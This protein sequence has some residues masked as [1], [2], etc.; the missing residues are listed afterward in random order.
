MSHEGTDAGMI[1]TEMIEPLRQD[2]FRRIWTASLLSNTG[3][4]IQGVGAGWAMVEMNGTPEQVALVQTAL[5]LP[6]TLFALP[7]GAIADIYDRRLVIL[8]SIIASLVGSVL[9]SIAVFG[10]QVGPASLLIFTFLVGSGMAL[11]GPSWQASVG[12][13]VTPALL[14][15]A[16]AL[17]SVSF[18]VARS[19]GPAIGGVIVA[20]AGV[21][22]AFIAAAVCYLPLIA[23]MIL[24]KRAREIPRLPPERLIEATV[25][26]LRYVLHSPRIRTP[27]W[28]TFSA[29]FAGTAIAALLPLIAR[30]IL[31]G[32]SRIFG[33]LLGA[34]GIGAVLGGLA[35]AS[36][37]AKFSTEAIM[38]LC[39]LSLAT[40]AVVVGSSHSQIV[41]SLALAVAG[42][43]WL[44]SVAICNISIQLTAPRW[45]AGRTLATFQAATAGG[46]ALGGWAWGRAATEIG[47]A[48][49]LYASAALLVLV[50]LILGRWMPMPIVNVEDKEMSAQRKELSA[51]LALTPRSGPIAVEIDYRIAPDRARQFYILVQELQRSRK[52]NGAR[53][54]SVARDI[55]DPWIWRER[56]VCATWL[57]FLR[58]R[59]RPTVKEAQIQKEV[60]ALHAGPE[61]IRAT[62]MLERPMGSV[63]WKEATPDHGLL[64]IAPSGVST[65]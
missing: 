53:S 40:M 23:V 5:T 41:T 42:A 29:A 22:A 59:D 37:R 36:L 3:R 44:I 20:W 13:Q 62:I 57:D 49:A 63:R 1:S 27:L 65:P 51:A 10:G 48:G 9:L 17:N 56:Y 31:H 19:F 18:N 43:C 11:F 64:P 30:D 50:A 39:S 2:L 35:L 6:I 55:R 54:C 26:G 45:V 4:M 24:W 8:F 25:A 60:A 14:P 28:R 7:A 38:R 61:A 34:F 47:L 33:L 21:A 32:D 16:I 12:E 52:R 46:I 58:Q 15:S